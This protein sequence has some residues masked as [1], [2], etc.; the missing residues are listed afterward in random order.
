M[1]IQGKLNSHDVSFEI[2]LMF[3]SNI[4]IIPCLSKLHLNAV[5]AFFGDSVYTDNSFV[6][7]Q[8]DIS[9][10]TSVRWQ[11]DVL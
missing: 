4:K 2:M 9:S 1:K 8:N 5:G 3:A 11:T 6:Y 10:V 7:N